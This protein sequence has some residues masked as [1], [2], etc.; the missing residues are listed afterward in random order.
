MFLAM[1][2]IGFV[3]GN[4]MAGGFDDNQPAPSVYVD[5]FN[6]EIVIENQVDKDFSVQV[7]DLTGKEISRTDV[8]DGS[9]IVR[10]KTAQLKRGIYLIRLTPVANAPSATFKIMLR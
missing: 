2:F 3:S 7:F 6:S 1:L 5:G 10:I 4:S 8:S 9:F